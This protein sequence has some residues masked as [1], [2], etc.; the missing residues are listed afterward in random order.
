MVYI[1]VASQAAKLL[2]TYDLRKLAKIKKI[3]KINGIIT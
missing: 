3:S 1:Q 2:K